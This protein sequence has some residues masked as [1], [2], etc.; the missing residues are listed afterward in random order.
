M[1]IINDFR[2]EYRWLSN[3]HLIDIKYK[4]KVYTSSESAYQAQKTDDIEWQEKI[5]LAPTPKEAKKLGAKC[6]LKPYW[7]NIRIIHMNNILN[8][9]FDNEELRQKLIDTK[10]SVL[11]EGNY[12]HDNFFGSCNCEK[13]GNKGANVLGTL[14]MLVR[15]GT[16]WAETGAE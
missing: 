8:I 15:D 3:Y 11:I 7:N 13:C 12:W 16:Q 9:K 6:P 2:G 4:G 10:D 14:L 1:N 5:R